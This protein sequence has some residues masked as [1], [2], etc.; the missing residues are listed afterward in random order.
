MHAHNLADTPANRDLARVEVEKRNTEAKAEAALPTAEHKIRL[1]AQLTAANQ[2]L[3]ANHADALQRGKAADEFL[4]K[5]NARHNM[6]VTQIDSAQ[7]ALDMSD[8]NM[9]AASITP[10]LATMTETTAQGI[11]RLNPQELNRFMPKSSGDAKQWFAAHYDQLVAGQIPE[12]YRSDLREL[13][14][15][16]SQEEKTQYD[17]N[18]ASI[19]QTVG[20]GAAT[21]KVTP[22]G[23]T[24]GATPRKPAAPTNVPTA[25][26]NKY[27][28]SGA[29]G[30]IVSNDGKTW[31]TLDGKQVGK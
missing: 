7:N 4:Q 31:Y 19:D 28:M 2:D 27:H 1:Q 29:K 3:N 14:N 21:P 17:A 9:L 23:K 12:T 6:R 20:R 10:I 15:N 26:N 22:E 11:K 18:V 16:M 30:E 5:E 24:A 13:L 25:Q 8:T